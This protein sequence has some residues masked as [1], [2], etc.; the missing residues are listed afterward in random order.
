VAV[1]RDPPR[2]GGAVSGG[3]AGAV[4]CG[5]GSFGA[6]GSV[7]RLFDWVK[8]S[9][10][11]AKRIRL[12]SRVRGGLICKTSSLHPAMDGPCSFYALVHAAQLVHQIGP[13]SRIQLEAVL[14]S[15]V[16]SNYLCSNIP[17][18]NFNLFLTFL[19]SSLIIGRT[20]PCRAL[21]LAGV[22]EARLRRRRLAR[23]RQRSSTR[24]RWP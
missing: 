4:V 10:G 8:K 19:P 14:L 24:R 17:Y 5:G 6:G 3:D 18:L 13:L 11:F 15:G 22:A 21:V 9:G 1:S 23:R 7:P 12:R 16:I 2:R 20:G